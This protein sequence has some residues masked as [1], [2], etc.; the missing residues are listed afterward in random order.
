MLIATEAVTKYRDFKIMLTY[1]HWTKPDGFD[2]LVHT[3]S[4]IGKIRIA[5]LVALFFLLSALFQ[6]CTTVGKFNE[7][8]NADLARRTN[9]FRW[10]EYAIS[11]SVMIIIIAMFTGISDL[12]ALIN[13]FWINACMNLFGLLMEHENSNSTDAVTATWRPFYFGVLAG[14]PP[15]ISIVTS[16]TAGGTGPPDFVYGIF[17]SYAVMFVTFPANMVLQYKRIS[18]WKDYRFGEY[19]YIVLSLVAKTLLGWLVFGGLNQPNSYT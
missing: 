11:S 7:V 19:C 3:V 2:G 10:Y 1:A 4:D 6:G 9:R 12:C 8:Y 13:M 18:Y 17:F 14:L 15:W 5:P 16:L